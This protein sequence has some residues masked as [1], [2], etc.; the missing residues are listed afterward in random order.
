MA[1]IRTIKPEFPQ[2]ESMGKISRDARLCFIELW[3][4]ADDSGRLR[5]A[6]RMLASL[7]FPYDDDAPG[8]INT[9]LDEL[10]RE[11]CI[12]RYIVDGHNYIQIAN[13]LSHQKIDKPSKSLFPSFANIREDSPNIRED[14]SEDQG[15]RTKEWTKEWKGEEPPFSQPEPKQSFESFCQFCVNQ[16]T[17]CELKPSFRFTTSLGLTSKEREGF[18]VALQ[19]YQCDEIEQAMNNYRDILNSPSHDA[20]PSGYSL[21]GFLGSGISQYLDESKPFERCKKKPDKNEKISSVEVPS[22]E[23]TREYI[24]RLREDEEAPAFEFSAAKVMDAI[25]NREN[26]VAK[27]AE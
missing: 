6:S 10:E 26:V 27:N 21:A 18:S 19:R 20:F 15:P 3:T 8:L 17:Q 1:R 7:L 14:S 22:A 2:S 25:R 11:G 5:A 16:W 9:W 24:E 23:E 12:T 13:W 4:I